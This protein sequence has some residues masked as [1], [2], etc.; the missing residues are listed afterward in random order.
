M[1]TY[2]GNR[3]K[4]ERTITLEENLFCV[5][6]ITKEYILYV[7]TTKNDLPLA[8]D[9]IR[10]VTEFFNKSGSTAAARLELI[11]KKTVEVPLP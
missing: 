5:V 9:G 6:N 7:F 2:T 11:L 10:K 1:C 3:L 8:F 4:I